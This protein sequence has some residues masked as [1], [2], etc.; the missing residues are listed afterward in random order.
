MDFGHDNVTAPAE[1]IF[2]QQLASLEEVVRHNM[3]SRFFAVS[4]V[5]F[6]CENHKFPGLS[7]A[8]HR[9]LLRARHLH[10]T[11]PARTKMSL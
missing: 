9:P 10:P 2:G 6:V 5:D 1:A 8:A 7:T 3:S 4:S 11:R